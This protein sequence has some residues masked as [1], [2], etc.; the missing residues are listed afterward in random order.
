MKVLLSLLLFSNIVFGQM[1][2]KNWKLI[3]SDST[4]MDD[5]AANTYKGASN[6]IAYFSINEPFW[7]PTDSTKIGLASDLSANYQGLVVNHFTNFERNKFFQDVHNST[8]EANITRGMSD[9]YGFRDAGRLERLFTV[10]LAATFGNNGRYYKTDNADILNLRLFTSNT[11]NNQAVITNFYGIRFENLRGVNQAIIQNG[12][13]IYIEPTQ[14]KNYFAGAVGVGTN[15]VSN[16]L[17]IAASSDPIKASGLQESND[18]MILTTDA[19]GVFHK[20]SVRNLKNYVF[21][22]TYG[23][24]ILQDNIEL[25]IHKGGNAIYTLPLPATCAGKSWIISNVGSGEITTSLPFYEG[26][27]QRS[28]ILNVPEAYTYHLFCDGISFISIK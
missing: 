10:K 23:H 18:S 13:G 3:T 9:T 16:Q 20:K 2:P 6:K 28:S 21:E 19:D 25:Y 5:L 14:F 11:P 27:V 7:E 26:N 22:I 8:I 1:I 15:A 17:T 4:A 12:W 24:T